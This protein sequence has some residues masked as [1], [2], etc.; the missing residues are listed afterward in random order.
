MLSVLDNSNVGIGT[1]EPNEK[2]DVV[3]NSTISGTIRGATY[4]FGG[5]YNSQNCSAYGNPFTGGCSCPSGF[6]AR[7]MNNNLFICY[8]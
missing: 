3:G 5:M 1:T 6:T 8:K 4:G 7:D 2:L